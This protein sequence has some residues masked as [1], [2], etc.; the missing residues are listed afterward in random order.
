MTSQADVPFR[1]V[2]FAPR[3]IAVDRRDDGTI[4]LSPRMALKL[5]EPHLPAYLRRHAGKRPDHCWLGQRRPKGADWERLTF[6]DA[7]A[8]AN[9]LT[10]GLLDLRLPA[11]KMLGILSANS[12]EQA[13][14]N[15]SAMQAHIPVVPISVAY[16]LQSKD[17]AKLKEVAGIV[18]IGIIFV[19][20]GKVFE[21]AIAALNLGVP[22][23]AVDN[24][25]PGQI[26]YADLLA[27]EPTDAVEASVAAI[28]PEQV[29]RIMFTSGST[30][31]PKGVPHSHRNIVVAAESNLQTN[32]HTTEGELARLDWTPWNHVFGAT[33]V[34]L[35]LVN[36]GTLMIDDGRPVPALFAETIRNLREFPTSSFVTVPSAYGL[37]IDALEADDELAAIF[38]SKLD[39]LGYG[40]ASLPEE[41]VRRLQ[42]LAIKHIGMKIS[43][44]CGYGATETGPG[45]A[46]I[47][48]STDRTGLI[49]LPHPGFEMKLVPLDDGRFEVRIRGE[50]VM[51]GYHGKPELNASIFDE[52]GFYKIGDTVRLADPADVMEGL[53]FAGRLSEEFKLTTGTFV[54]VGSLRLALL[55]AISSLVTDLVICGENRANISI[56]AWLN[57]EAARKLV[58]KPDAT[59]E[60][61]NADPAVIAA[62]AEGLAGHNRA[63]PG[64][65]TRVERFML[66]DEPP[67]IDDGEIT[68]KG[69]INQRGV[70]KRRADLVAAL[71][72]DKAA[73]N[74]H[75][76]AAAAV[77]A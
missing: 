71:F 45:G 48:W 19:Q 42:A 9:R 74:V 53:V 31:T 64:I 73:A 65:S 49:G 29:A 11:G 13:L 44:T 41:F 37:L 40:A 63:N 3:D 52:E 77:V 26:A 66:L 18:D 70:Q 16:S 6:G 34:A 61:L 32:G 15:I 21:A 39:M 56:L 67:S 60:E 51:R 33:G 30:G 5:N 55:G 4:V 7:L 25:Q 20:D 50:G 22:V 75:S 46:F 35:A 58:G 14:I 36:G 43:I 10:Q 54:L 8:K 72:E 17:F 23:I 76:V 68:D 57:I 69:S 24:V 27:T 28:D 47:Y 1:A 62:I 38:F 2:H 12:L 59:R